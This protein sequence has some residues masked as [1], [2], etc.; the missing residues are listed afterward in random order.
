MHSPLP[1]LRI[2]QTLLLLPILRWRTVGRPLK[3]VTLV[4]IPQEPGLDGAPDVISSVPFPLLV[5]GPRLLVTS[6][7]LKELTV[8]A[9]ANMPF[10]IR[11]WKLLML[12]SLHIPASPLPP[13]GLILQTYGNLPRQVT[14]ARTL[15][16]ARL[17][18]PALTITFLKHSPLPTPKVSWKAGTMFPFLLT[19]ASPDTRTPAPLAPIPN[20]NSTLLVSPLLGLLRHTPFVHT[21]RTSVAVRPEARLRSATLWPRTVRMLRLLHTALTQI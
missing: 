6:A 20:P 21:A 17:P 14:V 3:S 8:W 9:E 19:L 18:P 11:E 5:A 4:T 2:R 10:P 15:R 16:R 7:P 1:N 13:V 12:M